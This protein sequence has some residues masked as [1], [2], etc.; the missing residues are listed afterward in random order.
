MTKKSI[1]DQFRLKPIALE[2]RAK[3]MGKRK[4]SLNKIKKDCLRFERS[5]GVRNDPLKT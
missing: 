4:Y 1:V 5:V 3:T 2:N